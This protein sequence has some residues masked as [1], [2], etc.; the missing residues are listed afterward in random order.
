MLCKKIQHI[1]LTVMTVISLVSCNQQ[2][3][4]S[5]DSQHSETDSKQSVT[6]SQPPEQ[7]L[8][9]LVK[10]DNWSEEEIHSASLITTDGKRI[11]VPDDILGENGDMPENWAEK[12]IELS[13]NTLVEC[14]LPEEDLAVMYDFVNSADI[15]NVPVFKEYAETVYDAGFNT[16]YLL[17]KTY[18]IYTQRKLCVSGQTNEYIDDDKIIDF[19][20]FMSEKHYFVMYL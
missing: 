13:K 16:L 6:A 15:P 17:E 1:F 7:E 18:G 14:T 9:F 5:T 12:L 19:C 2:N 4:V 10:Y 11:K 3:T 8:M 20:N